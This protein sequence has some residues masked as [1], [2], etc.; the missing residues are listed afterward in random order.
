MRGVVCP[1]RC[2]VHSISTQQLCDW[3]Q[4]FIFCLVQISLHQCRCISCTW[5]IRVLR[6]SFVNV[7][8]CAIVGN[9]VM[10]SSAAARWHLHTRPALSSNILFEH[11]TSFVRYSYDVIYCLSW[12]SINV[13]RKEQQSSNLLSFCSA[14]T[15]L[16]RSFR[17]D[18]S[19]KPPSASVGFQLHLQL[20]LNTQL[21]LTFLPVRVET[22]PVSEFGINVRLRYER[23]SRRRTH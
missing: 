15:L 3:C 12:F 21:F 22:A 19:P 4:T 18:H 1:L 9:K 7:Q 14:G 17:R 10:C 6:S 13:W 11:N 2:R 23:S 16:L 20:L 5:L 8:C